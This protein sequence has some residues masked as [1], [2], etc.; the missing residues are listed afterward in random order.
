MFRAR[1]CIH[2]YFNGT[3]AGLIC[4]AIISTTGLTIFVGTI[5]ITGSF[6][7]LV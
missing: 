5:D 6:F 4:C 3:L 1:T 2:G 7:F